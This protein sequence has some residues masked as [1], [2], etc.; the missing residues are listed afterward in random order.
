MGKQVLYS[1]LIVIMG[2]AAG[3]AR[4][5]EGDPSLMGWWTF[6]GDALDASGNGRDGLISG[7]P[8][9][10]TGVYDKAIDRRLASYYDHHFGTSR[11]LFA[12]KEHLLPRADSFGEVACAR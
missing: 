10:V 3:T 7:D 12:V 11:D 1:I 6:D 8:L 5:Q 9:F 4:A 2:F